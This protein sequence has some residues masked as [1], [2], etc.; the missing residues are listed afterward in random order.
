[1]NG[2]QVHRVKK[3]LISRYQIELTE[4]HKGMATMIICGNG[5]VRKCIEM[6]EMAKEIFEE[7]L[8]KDEVDTTRTANKIQTGMMK[9]IIVLKGEMETMIIIPV[10]TK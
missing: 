10:L 2:A 4:V 5:T 9:E 6:N 7:A 8:M 3:G 1:M